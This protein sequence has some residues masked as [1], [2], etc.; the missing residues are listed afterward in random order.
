M[1]FS[2]KAVDGDPEGTTTNP[3]NGRVTGYVRESVDSVDDFDV[4]PFS[5]NTYAR[6]LSAVPDQH[7]FLYSTDDWQPVRSVSHLA[8][9]HIDLP[10]YSNAG[11]WLLLSSPGTSIEMVDMHWALVGGSP[12]WVGDSILRQP[13][14]TVIEA[15]DW[16]EDVDAFSVSVDGYRA[17]VESLDPHMASPP[18]TVGVSDV[19]VEWPFYLFDREYI[20]AAYQIRLVPFDPSP[21]IAP[22]SLSG[23]GRVVEP[24]DFDD[25][26]EFEFVLDQGEELLLPGGSFAAEVT[27]EG[28]SRGP[29]FPGYRCYYPRDTGG[30]AVNGTLR[31]IG[32]GRVGVEPV[33]DSLVMIIR[34]PANGTYCDLAN[35]P[36]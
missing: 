31:A 21:E 13:T 7:A 5:F 4:F 24:L 35:D 23:P 27:S 28:A 25:I 32:H 10:D 20:G 2:L 30:G 34:R 26:D 36:P 33:V 22:R 16:E 12:E 17:I 18:M 15:V 29:H 9:A 1:R 14:D 11:G 3:Y 6:W 19:V 8:L